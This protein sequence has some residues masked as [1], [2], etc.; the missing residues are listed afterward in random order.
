M[1]R[2]YDKV[3]L[4]WTFEGDFL[5]GPEGDLY[6]T[7]ADPLRSL[8][9]EVKTRLQSEQRD[10]G[11]FPRV[12][13]GMSELVGEPNNR[14]NAENGKAKIISALSRDGLVSASDISIKYIPITRESI[15]YRLSIAII[16][17]AGNYR[18][19]Y[20]QVNLLYN[21]TDNNLHFA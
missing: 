3:D 11:I 19:E 20:A 8:I 7:S 18:T 1:P 5:V 13:A 2:V 9:Q 15:L 17:T 12:G 4:Y 21:Y 16:A 6:D 10:W 14:E